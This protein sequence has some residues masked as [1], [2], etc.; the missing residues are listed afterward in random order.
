MK[1]RGFQAS[2]ETLERRDDFWPKTSRGNRGKRPTGN[3]RMQQ[4][5]DNGNLAKNKG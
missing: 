3:V 1:G 4:A 5:T 2:N